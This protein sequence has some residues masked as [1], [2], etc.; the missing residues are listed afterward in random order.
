M[1]KYIYNTTPIPKAQRTSRKRPTERLLRPGLLLQSSLFFK[2][3]K[4]EWLGGGED[5][6]GVREGRSK[7]WI[8]LRYIVWNS[9]IVNKILCY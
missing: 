2:G 7:G 8:L 9:Q 4:W 3:G 1:L 6:G 5:L